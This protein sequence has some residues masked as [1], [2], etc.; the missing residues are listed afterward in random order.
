VDNL[1]RLLLRAAL[2]PDAT[3]QA[4]WQEW[5][6][7]VDLNEVDPASQ[8]LLPLLA[9]RPWV[10]AGDPRARGLAR[11][12]YRH[13]WVRNQLLW[14]EAEAVVARLNSAR[15]PVLALKGLAL[16]TAYGFDWGLRPMH[17]VDIMVP[18]AS[19]DEAL[20]ALSTEGWLPLEHRT[21]QWIRTRGASRA[22]SVGFARGDN[23]Q[24]DLHWHVL[25]ESVGP[26][27]DAAFWSSAVGG[28]VLNTPVRFLQPAD[29]LLHVI[30][31]AVTGPNPP[32]AQW[33]ADVCHVVAAN[34]VEALAP[35]FAREAQRHGMVSRIAT[36][37][38]ICTDVVGPRFDVL[39]RAVA[40][41]PRSLVERIRPRPGEDVI[42]GLPS[43]RYHLARHI[44]GG[45]PLGGTWSLAADWLD[46]PLTAHPAQALVYAASRRPRLLPLVARTVG[47]RH[48]RTATG[49][50]EVVKPG[51]VLDFIDP[52]VFDSYAGPGWGYVDSGGAVMRGGEARLVFALAPLAPASQYVARFTVLVDE[53]SGGLRVLVNNRA[54]GTISAAESVAAVSD[55]PLRPST[56][57]RYPETEVAFRPVGRGRL[58]ARLLRVEFSAV[59]AS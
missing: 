35:R 39:R 4:A 37:L 34:P 30:A 9:R 7:S 55:V 45:R 48:S 33:I 20:E 29:L 53:R 42:T 17:D 31:H 16:L 52:E 38:D 8:R 47:L 10:I 28:H 44:A 40:A 5:L 2:L 14:R 58:R 15:I 6:A 19:L 56:V 50:L 25:S 46:L 32:E 54:A 43:I 24:L 18:R 1:H 27:A 11:G 22:H 21:T 36:G 3:G 59:P 13:A 51:D 41:R 57:N 26:R 49:L 23:G 12:L